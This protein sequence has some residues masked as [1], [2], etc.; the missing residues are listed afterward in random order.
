MNRRWK[1]A[2]LLNGLV[3]LALLGVGIDYLVSR[4]IK[5]HHHEIL[6][7]PWTTLTPRTQ[8]LIMTL[9]KGTGLSAIVGAV[10][11]GI[12]LA[13]PFRKR[14]R[15]ARGALVAVGATVLVPAL[16][17]TFQVR[18]ETGASAPWWPHVVLLGCLGA[19]FWLTRDFDNP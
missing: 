6:D 10:S 1:I 9:L 17:G 15:W 13:F 14:Q 19:A 18:A 2:A 11:M 8:L 4:E 5:P 16:L 7:V 12:L 3:V